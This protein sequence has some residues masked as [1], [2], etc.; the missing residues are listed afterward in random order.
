MASLSRQGTC[1]RVG[2]VNRHHHTAAT[3]TA[4]TN[5]EP[6]AALAASS[7][8]GSDFPV[9]DDPLGSYN[10]KTATATTA[11]SHLPRPDAVDP[12]CTATPART[13]VKDNA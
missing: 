12:A 13:P 10:H 3:A 6:G 5:Q 2:A 4:A 1:P 8:I 7:A 11:A 9:I